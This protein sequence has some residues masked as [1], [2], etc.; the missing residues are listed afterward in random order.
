M[1]KRLL[2]LTL[3]TSIACAGVA[4]AQSVGSTPNGTATT[5]PGTTMTMTMPAMPAMPGMPTITASSNGA[6]ESITAGELCAIG[7][8][9]VVG[10]VL[11]QGAVWHG[12]TIMGA[13]MGGWAGD[14]LYNSRAAVKTAS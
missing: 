4:H 8:G 2:I 12:M 13:M 10:V 6:S 14:Y 1:L 11:F 9:V 5:K 3:S 7:V